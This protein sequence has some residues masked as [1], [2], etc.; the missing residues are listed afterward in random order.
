MIAGA[1][2]QFIERLALNELHY[3]RQLRLLLHESEAMHDVR[4]RQP[5][6]DLRFASELVPSATTSSDQRVQDLDCYRV[7]RRVLEPAG[8]TVI[9]PAAV[10]DAHPAF[11]N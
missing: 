6:E 2:D 3:D 11:P 5:A 1:L 9:K 4:M 7:R 10:H 8:R